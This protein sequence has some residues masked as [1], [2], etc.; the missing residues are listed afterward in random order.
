MANG[1]DQQVAALQLRHPAKK[2]DVR[3]G[4]ARRYAGV[5]R[6]RGKEGVDVHARGVAPVSHVLAAHVLAGHDDGG[7]SLEE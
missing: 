6:V 4:G 5:G 7:V 1:A 2:D 3:L